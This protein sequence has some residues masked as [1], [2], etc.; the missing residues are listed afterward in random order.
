MEKELNQCPCNPACKCE[1]DEPCLGCEEYGNWIYT[2]PSSQW[3]SEFKNM[4]IAFASSIEDYTNMHFKA[5]KMKP[6]EVKEMMTMKFPLIQTTAMQALICKIS[7]QDYCSKK[8]AKE[9]ERF[10]NL[11]SEP[12]SE[13]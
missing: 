3:V 11:I 13:E 6:N 7:K 4:V 10:N 1:M 12:P 8:A 2:R 9:I 5:W